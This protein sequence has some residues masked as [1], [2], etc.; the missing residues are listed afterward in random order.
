MNHESLFEYA[1][2]LNK[3]CSQWSPRKLQVTYGQPEAVAA[4]Q[5]RENQM[6]DQVK[7]E[8]TKT[9]TITLRR[10]KVIE[11]LNDAGYDISPSAGIFAHPDVDT[12]TIAWT[13]K[14]KD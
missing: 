12:V 14:V 2:R 7:I 4:A 11:A 3:E 10:R 9:A 8:V 13:E 6:K 5:K 1:K